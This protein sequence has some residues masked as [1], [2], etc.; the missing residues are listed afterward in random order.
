MLVTGARWCD[1][2]S[3]FPGL[4]FLCVR[5]ERDPMYQRALEIAL[6]L[7]CND[8]DQLERELREHPETVL[9]AA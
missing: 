3:Y 9:E 6:D 7:F 5:V 4:P 8:L 1:I 2:V